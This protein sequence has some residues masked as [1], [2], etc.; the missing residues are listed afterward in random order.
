M[1]I[2]VSCKPHLAKMSTRSI[3]QHTQRNHRSREL[4][5]DWTLNS[6]GRCTELES[7]PVSRRNHNRRE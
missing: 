2:N 1:S 3:S 7:T 4:H 5:L 6:K